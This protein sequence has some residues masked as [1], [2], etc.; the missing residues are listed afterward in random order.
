VPTLVAFREGR[1]TL[2]IGAGQVEEQD[3]ERNVEQVAPTPDQMVEQR[4]LV[5]E[6]PI[7]TAVEFM[8]LRQSDIL[9]QQVGHGAAL[10]PLAMQAPL[11]ARRQ[12]PVG[13]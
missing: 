8:D 11:A 5:F 7:V 10:E 13:S 4:L 3:V 1:I 6:Q 2:E 9:A 12:Q